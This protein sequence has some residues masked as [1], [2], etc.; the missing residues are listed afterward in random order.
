MLLSLKEVRGS[1]SMLLATE[2]RFRLRNGERPSI[3]EYRRRFRGHEV[4]TEAVIAG[5]VVPERIGPFGVVRFLGE[6]N[7]GRVYLGRDKQLD[8]FVAIKV[9]RPERLSGPEDRDRFVLEA[10]L[11]ARIKHSGI[12]T[13]Y[14]GRVRSGGGLLRGHRSTSRDGRSPPCSAARRLTYTRAA[15]MMIPVAEAISYAHEQ[16]LVHRDLK[17]ENILLDTKDQ[18]H[19]ADFGLAVH[20]DDRWPG[21]GEVAGSPAYM[22]PEQV[23]GETHRLNGRTDVWA[24]GVILYRML[25]GTRPFEG[26]NTDQVFDEILNRDPLPVRQR[27]RSVPKELE[28]ICMKCLSKRMT[29][30]YGTAGDFAEDLRYWLRSAGRELLVDQ[31]GAYANLAD[32]ERTPRPIEPIASASGMSSPAR[33][34]PKGLKGV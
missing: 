27:D 28:R 16:G 12:V 32:G 15:E 5:A 18:P 17:P 11:A 3:D 1:L 20:Q 4:L 34:R 2:L 21:Q 19:I 24:L 30:R 10:R 26:A 22:A 33:V 6:G 25:T 31:A 29:D 14:P 8:R 13:V 7:F 9:P 23:R